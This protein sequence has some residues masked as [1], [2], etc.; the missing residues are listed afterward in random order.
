MC[1]KS[2]LEPFQHHAMNLLYELSTVFFQ[3]RM[4]IGMMSETSICS[5]YIA[6]YDIRVLYIE[7]VYHLV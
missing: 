4:L 5:K 6:W 2:D 1:A 3:K 7:K